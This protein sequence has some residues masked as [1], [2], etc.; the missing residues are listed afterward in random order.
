VTGR[1]RAL[2]IL[3][4]AIVLVLLPAAV[5][6]HPLGNFTINHYAGIVVSRSSVALDVVIDMA[7]I[8]TLDEVPLLDA[9]ANATVTPAEL[10]AARVPRCEALLDQLRLTVGG[11]AV[12]LRLRAA[13]LHLRPGAA[14]LDTLRLVCELR[15]PV[16]VPDGV[17]LGFEDVSYADRLGWREIVVR[18]D[19][20]TVEGGAA[21]VTDRLTSYPTD[22][23]QQPLGARSSTVIVRSGGPR[24]P[25]TTVDDATPVD[26]A[27]QANP[28]PVAAT[29]DGV[30]L[31][32]EIDLADP[33][34]LVVILALSLAAVAGGGHALSPGHGKTVM[35]A[36]LIGTRG[37]ARDALVLGAAVTASHTIG[38]LALAVVVLLLG[39]VLP[40]ERLFPVLSAV[41][42]ITVAAIGGTL[43]LGCLRRWAALA[44][45]HHADAHDHAH[46]GVRHAHGGR[47]H[48]HPAP[49]SAGWRGLA[50]IGIAGGMIPST[51][52]L[53]LLLGAVAAGQPALGVALA[54]AFGMGMAVVLA[55]L[56]IVIVRGRGRLSRLADRVPRLAAITPAVP[57]MAALIV[58][59]SGVVL[60]AQ[61]LA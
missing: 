7:E 1:A 27:G 35:A 6:A 29:P 2:G 8:P 51:A 20:M 26:A 31:P 14:G 50:A 23:L 44:D 55:G 18:G 49:A 52:A 59:A 24:L 12:A 57:W 46:H 40:P 56:G 38:V 54:I 30:G 16:A 21:D 28:A 42:G 60:T 33:S 39:E 17:E 61:A 53:V 10:D 47:S 19:G 34:P 32:W 22:L 13:G 5:S 4:G 37:R 9:D 11:G 45:D 36:Y 25:A 43:L 3:L 15:A 41:S 58:M 48:V